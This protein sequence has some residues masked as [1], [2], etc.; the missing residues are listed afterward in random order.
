MILLGDEHQDL[1]HD[2]CR[3][4]HLPDLTPL[5]SQAERFGTVF[6]TDDVTSVN[7]DE[8]PKVVRVGDETYTANSVVLAMS[9]AYRELRVPGEKELSGHGVWRRRRSSPASRGRPRLCTAATRCAP[10]GS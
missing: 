4:P 7:L 6:I 3:R 1:W 9:S 8:S 2:L 10:R 5:R